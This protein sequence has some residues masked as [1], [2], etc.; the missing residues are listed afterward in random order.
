MAGIRKIFGVGVFGGLVQRRGVDVNV[1]EIG[2]R[3]GI[4]CFGGIWGFYAVLRREFFG[5]NLKLVILEFLGGG[6][7][8][9]GRRGAS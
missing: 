7:T 6:L 2:S 8:W 4:Y 5:G 1:P 9:V 3:G